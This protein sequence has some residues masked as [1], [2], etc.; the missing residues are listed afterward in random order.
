VFFF[1]LAKKDCLSD[2]EVTYVDLSFLYKD[3]EH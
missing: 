3:L 2:G 1:S